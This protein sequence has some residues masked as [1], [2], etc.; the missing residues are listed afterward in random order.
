MS[1][2]DGRR[3]AGSRFD[4]DD[5]SGDPV[6][7][8]ALARDDATAMSRLLDARLLVPVVA[9]LG[10]LIAS[11]VTDGSDFGPQQAWFYVTLL[12]IGYMVSRGL[13]KA[14]SRDF[15]DDDAD[16]DNR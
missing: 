9:V 2:F 16:R 6:L 12:T 13:A 7:R 14:G 15:Y 11:A 8:D 10:V 1:H 4:G 5:G 3:I